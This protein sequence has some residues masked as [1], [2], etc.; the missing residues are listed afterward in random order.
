T[1]DDPRYDGAT[2]LVQRKYRENLERW[3]ADSFEVR[4]TFGKVFRGEEGRQH[5]IGRDRETGKVIRRSDG[6]LLDAEPDSADANLGYNEPHV[7]RA[8]GGVIAPFAGPSPPL[9]PGETNVFTT[10]DI[11]IR[12]RGAN[13]SEIDPA[14]G[15]VTYGLHFLCYQNNIQQT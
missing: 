13:F 11:R 2:Y 1:R 10:Q 14:T 9:K 3:N 15:G 5:A 7:T 8:R 4:D 6:R 12:R